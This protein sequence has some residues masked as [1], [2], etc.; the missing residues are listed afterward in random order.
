MT[1]FEMAKAEMWPTPPPSYDIFV[2]EM[3]RYAE[4]YPK[5]QAMVRAAQEQA[6]Q[7]VLLQWQKHQGIPVYGFVDAT[8][9]DRPAI[10]R[11]CEAARLITVAEREKEV[12][13]ARERAQKTLHDA[14]TAE[15]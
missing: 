10:I 5:V 2:S 6:K 7:E 1:K 14:M 8:G 9:L 3:S 13:N 11:E 4:V 12:D 15:F